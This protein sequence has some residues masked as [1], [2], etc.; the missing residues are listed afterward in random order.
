MTERE[1]A[2]IID[3][4]KRTVLSAIQTHLA[5]RFYHA[6]DDVAQET[7]IRAYRSL[8]KKKFKEESL[9]STWLYTIAKNESLRMNKKMSREE[10]KFE[11]SI[12]KMK[13]V[14]AYKT[15]EYNHDIELL[16]EAIGNLPEKYRSVLEL[17]SRGLTE[18]QISE[19]LEIKIGTVKSRSSRGREMLE[20][21][22]KGGV[23]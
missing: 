18:K 19:K 6:I 2:E 14:A 9:I 5:D 22:L 10:M 15:E 20:K 8:V 11:K 1:F 4:T 13:T 21:L 3:S 17:V 16:R 7:Y 23:Q 12:E